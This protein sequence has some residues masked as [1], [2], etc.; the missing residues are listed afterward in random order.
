MRRKLKPRTILIKL[1]SPTHYPTMFLL[2]I[3][4]VSIASIN[5]RMRRLYGASTL[6]GDENP[7]GVGIFD[8]TEAI[9]SDYWITYAGF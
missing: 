1:S 3:S 7:V 6:S 5:K 2:T 4:K 9:M 8:L